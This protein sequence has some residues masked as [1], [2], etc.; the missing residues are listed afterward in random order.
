MEKPRKLDFNIALITKEELSK[1]DIKLFLTVVRD[2]GPKGIISPYTHTYSNGNKANVFV[3][4][5]VADDGF[6]YQVPL[7]RNLTGNEADAIV[8]EWMDEYSGDFDIEATSPVLRMQDLSMF[9]EVEVDE[10]YETLALNA[11]NNIKHQ[12]W[13][14]EHVN[15]GWRYGMK[16]SDD[17]KV[18]PFLLPWEQ[19]SE[20]GKEK[21]VKEYASK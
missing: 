9:D 5:S 14:T 3:V 8:G 15:N 13:M 19:L 17:D 11:E 20:N 18:C 2:M 16:H 21:W 1:E 12:R 10:S 4:M 6:K 7:K